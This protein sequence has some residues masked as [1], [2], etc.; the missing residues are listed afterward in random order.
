[1]T[2]QLRRREAAV[3]SMSDLMVVLD[4][5]LYVIEANRP[6][7]AYIGSEQGD[8]VGHSLREMIGKAQFDRTLA[9]PLERCLSGQQAR[10]TLELTFAAAGRRRIEFRLSPLID[11]AHAIYAVVATGHNLP[12]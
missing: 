11:D 5:K 6:F 9:Q 7:M 1:M 4:S 12:D 8:V 10:L 2:H 3:Q